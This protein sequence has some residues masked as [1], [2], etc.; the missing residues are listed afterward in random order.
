M[1]SEVLSKP[2]FN[3][4]EAVTSKIVAAIEAGAGRYVTPWHTHG[5]PISIPTNATT[6]AEY[7]GVNILALWAHSMAYGYSSGLWASYKQWQ[8][9]GAQVR[10]GESGALIVFYKRVESTPHDPQD[11]N[12]R[13]ELQFVARASFVFN[14]V[15]VDGYEPPPLK[16]R[17]VFESCAEAEEFAKATGAKVE[18]GAG[19][20]AYNRKS[21]VILMPSRDIFVGTQTS[22]AKE[23]YYATLLHEL[24]HWSGAPQRLNREYGKRFGDQAYAMEELTAELGAAIMCSVF[25]IASEP[26]PDHA[27]YIANWL[28]VLK[29]DSKAIF[30]AA[31][32]AQEA[33]EHL[34]YLASKMEEPRDI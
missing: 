32:K 12:R 25:G 5:Q 31:S 30:T 3:V 10:K 13:A 28:Q 27:A 21:D 22:S 19:M 16:Q 7:R 11:H 26:R 4:Y 6:H 18:H 1:T 20:A 17:S 15:Q 23:A 14:A 2:K 29:Q 34:A 24:T 33:F 9:V 8:G